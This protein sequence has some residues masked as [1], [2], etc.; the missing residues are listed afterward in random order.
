MTHVIPF[1]KMVGTGNDFIVVDARHNGFAKL[2]RQWKTISQTLCDRHQGIGSDGILVLERSKNALATMRI[3][4]PDGS[5]AEMC[6]NG[7]R[8]VA[9]Y[10]TRTTPRSRAAS[11]A[12][13][14]ETLAG[15][16]SARVKDS[17]VA[18]RMSNPRDIRLNQQ[19]KLH[20]KLMRYHF[21]NTG[22]PHAVF[23]MANL[24]TIDV[25]TLGEQ[26]RFHDAF[27]PQGSNINFMTKRRSPLRV[28]TY[29]R[30]VEH[31]TL[32]CGTGMVATAIISVLAAHP[33]GRYH[34]IRIQPMSGEHVTVSFT[35][36][37]IRGRW[38]IHDV[39]LEGLARYVFDGQV[40]WPRRRA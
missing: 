29:E 25:N 6:G 2:R 10:L 3:F 11:S 32:A 9:L 12:V 4:N 7:A 5:E 21:I 13:T 14:F 36:A 34:R 22:V 18:L 40:S 27:R 23:P 35:A 8:C 24:Q 17:R 1:T 20:G 37:Q 28:R 39:V 38:A 33:K 19:L 26:L 31:E 30:G 16:M 15:I